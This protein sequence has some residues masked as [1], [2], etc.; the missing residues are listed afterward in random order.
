MANMYTVLW[1]WDELRTFAAKLSIAWPMEE[2][3]KK[4]AFNW[5][6]REYNITGTQQLSIDGP[7]ASGKSGGDLPWLEA[8]LFGQ[9]PTQL[10]RFAEVVL[11]EC[12]AA[13]GVQVYNGSLCAAQ[14]CTRCKPVHSSQNELWTAI[15][16]TAQGG[17][18]VFTSALSTASTC[19]S[20]NIPTD[21]SLANHQVIA[22]PD[23]TC[24]LWARQSTFVNTSNGL[25]KTTGFTTSACSSVDGCCIEA[26]SNQSSS[27]LVVAACNPQNVLQQFEVDMNGT[28][29]GRIKDRLTGRCLGIR[30][31]V[32]GD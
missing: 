13:T 27:T 6:A 26:A 14:E 3:T 23:T 15:N 20:L 2:Q 1:R 24:D 29:P 22:Y 16:S 9:C 5:F 21:L 7:T 8:C 17:G 18:T 11:D 10:L 19:Y 31:C 28:A 30:Q 4:A 12:G 32:A 25:L